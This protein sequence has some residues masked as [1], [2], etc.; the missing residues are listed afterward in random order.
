MTKKNEII[1][2]FTNRLWEKLAQ[3]SPHEVAVSLLFRDGLRVAY[4]LLYNDKWDYD[5]QQYSVKLFYA[6]RNVH[7]DD[8]NRS[9]E[10][11]ALL[12][13]ACYLTCRHEERYKAYK[14]AFDRCSN[15]PPGLLIELARCCICPG[16]PPIPCDHAISLVMKSIKEFPYSD[17]VGLLCEL[18][19]SKDDIANKEYWSTILKNLKNEKHSPS[20][21]P[22]FLVDE[23]FGK[24]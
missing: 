7:T 12:G 11:D 8:W 14:R 5:L 6:L 16:D 4:R 20:I 21:E 23:F 24:K 13:L 9:W 1:Q 17:G 18:Y 19:S 22:K 10:Y 3:Y 15:P 2:L